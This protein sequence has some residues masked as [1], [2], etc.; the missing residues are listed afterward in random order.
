MIKR[1]SKTDDSQEMR[2]REGESLMAEPYLSR[3]FIIDF[4][5]NKLENTLR[6]CLSLTNTQG[7]TGFTHFQPI[8]RD[9]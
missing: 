8:Y 4:L 1:K 5:I 3:I 9:F 2:E 7:S 6:I